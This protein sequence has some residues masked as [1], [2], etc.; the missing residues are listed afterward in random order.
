MLSVTFA[1]T[2]NCVAEIFTTL[3][4][5]LGK[6]I[7]CNDSCDGT[8]GTMISIFHVHVSADLQQHTL[9][10]TMLQLQKGI[11]IGKKTIFINCSNL[12]NRLIILA[13]VKS[14]LKF[15]V[16]GLSTARLHHLQ[17]R[18]PL[19]TDHDYADIPNICNPSEY[20][21]AAVSYIAWNEAQ[22]VKRCTAAGNTERS[23]SKVK[24]W[25]RASP[26]GAAA[27]TQRKSV[28]YG[29]FWGLKNTHFNNLVFNWL[30]C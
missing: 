17:P 11:V 8:H 20:K 12:F 4:Q 3:M 18:A 16:A 5:H 28:Q 9:N 27:S 23:N 1:R 30:I 7:Y 24:I 10:E 15:C 25:G 29:A 22:E 19:G 21:H 2:I 26:C 13:E 14:R 6:I